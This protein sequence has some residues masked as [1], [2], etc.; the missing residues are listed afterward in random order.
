MITD[1]AAQNAEV[2]LTPNDE[3]EGTAA[4]VDLPAE[5]DISN[6]GEVREMLADA[7]DRRPAVV[8]ADGTQTTFCSSCGVSMLLEANHRAI[9]VGAQLRLVATAAEVR[10]ILQLT[11]ADSELAVYPSLETAVQANGARTLYPAGEAMQR[12]ADTMLRYAPGRLS[13]EQR[14]VLLALT[15]G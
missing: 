6:E 12:A 11:G 7:L 15:T 13:P 1:P 3:P 4:L 5:I 10:R 8:I 14:R 9:S 2:P